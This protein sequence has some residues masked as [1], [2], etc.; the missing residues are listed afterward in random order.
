MFKEE[1]LLEMG[2][3]FFETQGRSFVRGNCFDGGIPG[4]NVMYCN[5]ST[6][7]TN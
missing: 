7:Q 3:F 1:G 6:S 4:G 2:N 5:L